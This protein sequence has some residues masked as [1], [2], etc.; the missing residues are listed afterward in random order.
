MF[1]FWPRVLMA[2]LTA[3]VGLGLGYW[4]GTAWGYSLLGSGLGV[5][6]IRLVPDRNHVHAQFSG[7]LEC[8]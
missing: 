5:A 2:V 1:W 6:A 3:L 7:L 8:A 4:L